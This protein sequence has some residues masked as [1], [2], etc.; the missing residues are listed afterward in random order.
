MLR[1]FFLDDDDASPGRTAPAATAPRWLGNGCPDH[2]HYARDDFLSNCAAAPA[3]DPLR[4]RPSIGRVWL[5]APEE[6]DGPGAGRWHIESPIKI[7]RSCH[8]EAAVPKGLENRSWATTPSKR[9]NREPTGPRRQL[10]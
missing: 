8:C 1:A 7:L 2:P 6:L 4:V 3:S 10:R 5:Q 9:A